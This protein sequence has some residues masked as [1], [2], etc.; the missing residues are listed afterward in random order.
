MNF[1]QPLQDALGAFLAFLSPLREGEF[2]AMA[3]ASCRSG[4]SSSDLRSVLGLEGK[5][6]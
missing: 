4:E 5:S 6:R 2:G 1:V 3:R